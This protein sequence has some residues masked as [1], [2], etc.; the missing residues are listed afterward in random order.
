MAQ[1]SV[2][3]PCRDFVLLTCPGP[4]WAQLRHTLDRAA[5]TCHTHSPTHTHHPRACL[6]TLV[7]YHPRTCLYTHTHATHTPVCTHLPHPHAFLYTHH[8]RACLYTLLTPTKSQ[9][10]KT[11]LTKVPRWPTTV[12]LHSEQRMPESRP[13]PPQAQPGALGSLFPLRSSRG[14]QVGQSH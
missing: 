2:T 1:V 9:W 3:F 8:P 5:H 11:S 10:I 12:W 7:Q 14:F 6:Y 13:S 4:K